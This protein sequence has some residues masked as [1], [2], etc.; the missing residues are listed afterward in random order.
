MALCSLVI[1]V[2]RRIER[3]RNGVWEAQKIH[4]NMW[5]SIILFSLYNLYAKFKLFFPILFCKMYSWTLFFFFIMNRYTCVFYVTRHDTTD[6]IT[7]TVHRETHK[8]KKGLTCFYYFIFHLD[9]AYFIYFVFVCVC[10]LITFKNIIKTCC[11]MICGKRLPPSQ[12]N[13]K[14]HAIVD[15]LDSLNDT[16]QNKWNL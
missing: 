14:K 10:V 7:H 13:I 3:D 4:I 8:Q 16:L 5:F 9:G 12:H 11:K 1:L 15:A 6:K 2:I